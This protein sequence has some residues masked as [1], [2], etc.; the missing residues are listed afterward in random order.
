MIRRPPRSTRTDTLFPY[1]TLFRPARLI[2]HLHTALIIAL[3]GLLA[4][5]VGPGAGPQN[6]QA[7][8]TDSLEAQVDSLMAEYDREDSP[9]AVVGV[10]RDGEVSFAK[11]YGMADLAHQI[12]ITPETRFNIGSASKQFLGFAFALLAEQGTLS[13]EDPVREHLPDWPQFSRTVTLRHL[14]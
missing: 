5:A 12:P 11:G 2:R 3:V 1:T 10:F 4:G 6:T 13:L 7:Q 8:S 14:L 9:G